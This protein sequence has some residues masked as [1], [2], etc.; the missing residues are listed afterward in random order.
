MVALRQLALP[1]V[2][3]QHRVA[4]TIHAVGEVLARHAND[5]TFPTLQVA[6]VEEIPVLHKLP[7]STSVLVRVERF[8]QGRNR[9]ELLSHLSL[10][11]AEAPALH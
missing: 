8:R 9:Q 10:C 7:A 5:T 6:I 2:A 3:G 1:E 4:V 11:F